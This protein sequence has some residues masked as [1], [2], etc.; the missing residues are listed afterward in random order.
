M[1]TPWASAWFWDH[2]KLFQMDVRVTKVTLLSSFNPNP[3]T[4]VAGFRFAK[5]GRLLLLLLQLLELLFLLLLLLLLLLILLMFLLLL[6]LLF[7]LLLLYMCRRLT[8]P[9]NSSYR[10]ASKC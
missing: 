7:L 5:L 10:F 6:L 2:W 4:R 1:L 8:E 3:V 9:C